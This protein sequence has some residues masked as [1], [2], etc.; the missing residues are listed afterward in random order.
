MGNF[1]LY[2]VQEFGVRAS[3]GTVRGTTV[4][5]VKLCNRNYLL[6]GSGQERIVMR[7][8]ARSLKI[9]TVNGVMG[10]MERNVMAYI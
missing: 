2:I 4:R 8:G 1:H 3:R 6:Q 5:H 9:R 7:L 10:A